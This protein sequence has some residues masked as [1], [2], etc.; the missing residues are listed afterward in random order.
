MEQP[1][2]LTTLQIPSSTLQLVQAPGYIAHSS[3][4]IVTKALDQEVKHW[5]MKKLRNCLVCN[6]IISIMYQFFS[7]WSCLCLCFYLL[8]FQ[9]PIIHSKL[10]AMEYDEPSEVQK[11]EQMLHLTLLY[12]CYIFLILMLLLI[13]FHPQQSFILYQRIIHKCLFCSAAIAAD[14]P[15][16]EVAADMYV[17]LGESEPHVSV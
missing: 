17:I 3:V 2:V 8:F 6:R 12:I 1:L 4:I 14:R 7:I 15:Q 10:K 16:H 13:W 9:G 5:K 11:N